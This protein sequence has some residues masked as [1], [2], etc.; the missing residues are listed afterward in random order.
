MYK[1]QALLGAAGRR[2]EAVAL[3]REAAAILTEIDAAGEI[4]RINMRLRGLGARRLREREQRPAFG[5]DSLTPMERD[6]GLLV[7][8]GLTNPEIGA[9]L[10]I[11]RRT[12]ETHLSHAF[13]KLGLASRT[14]LAAAIARRRADNPARAAS[15]G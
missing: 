8:S 9:R 11:S 4:A 2:D 5:W 3:L 6:V 14:Q 15:P 12:V 10:A 1:R 13:R 7:A